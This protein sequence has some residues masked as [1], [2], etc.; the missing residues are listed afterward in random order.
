LLL[1]IRNFLTLFLSIEVSKAM[2]GV[3]EARDVGDIE[4][5]Q[6]SQTMVDYF[7]DQMNESNPILTQISNAMTE[8][9]E[10]AE[11]IQELYISK[12]YEEINAWE[13]KLTAA[14]E[15]KIVGN[16]KLME[17]SLRFNEMMKRLRESR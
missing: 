6:Y 16:E 4:R 12:K 10:C 5:M 15:S 14:R 13:S 17:C 11:K 9:G 1:G 7:T 3:I 2:Q 8:E